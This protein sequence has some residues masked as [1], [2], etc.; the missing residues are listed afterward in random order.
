MGTH[1]R[2]AITRNAIHT[3][4]E[5]TMDGHYAMEDLTDPF[6]VGFNG[7][8]PNLDPTMEDQTD[9]CEQEGFAHV[10]YDSK[11]LYTSQCDP[12]KFLDKSLSAKECQVRKALNV[13]AFDIKKIENAFEFDN[14]KEVNDIVE[15]FSLILKNESKLYELGWKVHY[16][17]WTCP[18]FIACINA[19]R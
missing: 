17:I 8:I 13:F 19:E 16:N 1:G 14:V 11:I 4:C 2:N 3:C 18:T 15:R 12:N 6:L 5:Q 9:E 10:D 7:I